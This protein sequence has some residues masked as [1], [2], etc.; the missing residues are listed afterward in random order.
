MGRGVDSQSHREKSMTKTASIDVGALIEGQKLGHFQIGLMAWICTF[1]LIEGYDMQVVGYA[2]PAIIK[3]WHSD[4]AAFG[5]V[6]GA[7]LGGFMLGATVLGNF[8]DRFGRKRM[9]V[10]GSLLFGLFTLASA[11]AEGLTSLLVLRTIAGIGLGGSIPNA[12]AL[13][14][15]YSPLRERATRIGIIFIGYT[16][17]SA[18]GGVIAAQLI[19]AWGWPSVFI[20]G[21]VLPIAIGFV[22]LFVLPESVRFLIVKRGR[23]DQVLSLMRRIRPDLT[24]SDDT[25]FAAEEE[26]KEGLPLA[27]LF[28]DGR[29]SMTALLWLAYAANMISLHFLTSWLPTVFAE[30][31]VPLSHA[32][33]AT[34]LLQGGGAVGSLVIGRLLDRIGTLGIVAAFLVAVPCVA[35]LG[36]V[37]TS[38]TP[39]MALVTVAGLCIIGGQVGINA[40]AG[41]LYPTY[42]RSTG[43]G[44]AFGVGRVGSILGPVIGGQLLA[45]G[46]SLGLLF[47]AA[48][49]P[50]LISAGALFFL[51]R[52]PLVR[53]RAEGVEASSGAMPS[54]LYPASESPR[55]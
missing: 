34:A 24:F 40:L 43:T 8:G 42:M 10:A 18:L 31:G 29:A 35:A 11:W 30:S 19:P 33:L 49:T 50:V 9:I 39:L 5:V 41:T 13:V 32:V 44:W 20:V 54:P 52:L 25:A 22:S 38:E 26:N 36:H 27:H 3:A 47:A 15:E 4:K 1:M 17:G 12:I 23:A 45:V 48:S 55:P 7:G 14:T 37:G 21:G 6:F 53:N 2:A 16:V 28:A 46:L 51:G